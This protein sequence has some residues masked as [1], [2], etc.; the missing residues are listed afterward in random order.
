MRR[1]A[2]K[3]SGRAVGYLRVSTDKQADSG[4]GL[5][6]Q[7][8]AIEVAAK[9]SGR[10]LGR[11][12]IDGGTSGALSVTDRPILMEAIGALRRGD[13]LL[14]AKRDRIGR[15]V[16]VVATIE[17]AI[18][19]RGGRVISAAGEGTDADNPSDAL[20][21]RMI[22]SF[23]QYERELIAARTKAALQAKRA[24]GERVSRFAPFG[25]TFT[26]AGRLEQA[27]GEQGVL[28]ALRAC[29][30]RGL[31]IRATAAELNRQGMR[32]RAGSEWRFEYVRNLLGSRSPGPASPV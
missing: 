21:R 18:E 20:M 4:L 3:S 22:D 7:Q 27:E 8:A 29:H 16:I 26:E 12:F 25:W 30:A 10:Q 5:E 14:V 32:T 31:S 17:K 6:A 9:R 28:Q 24:R 1:S 13:V 23:S 19:K 2:P 11:V 15:D